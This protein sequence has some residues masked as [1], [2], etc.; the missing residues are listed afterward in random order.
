MSHLRLYSSVIYSA[1]NSDMFVTKEI[2]LLSSLRTVLLQRTG[3]FD[4]I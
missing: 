4:F 2:G 1:G 3:Y